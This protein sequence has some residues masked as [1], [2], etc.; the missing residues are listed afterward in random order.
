MTT[1]TNA[2][3]LA[4]DDRLDTIPTSEIIRR[5]TDYRCLKL[6]QTAIGLPVVFTDEDFMDRLKEE[7]DRRI[8]APGD[9][10]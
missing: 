4:D 8:P 5:L 6:M 7:L 2:S 3:V 1:T 10:S 9:L